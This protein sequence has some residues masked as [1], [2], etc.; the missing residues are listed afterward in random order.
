MIVRCCVNFLGLENRNLFTSERAAVTKS[1]LLDQ[2]I[3]CLTHRIWGEAAYRNM[4]GPK[5]AAPTDNYR[6]I[7]YWEAREISLISQAW[8]PASCFI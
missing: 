2:A 6:G 3:Y 5:T 1:S 7:P 8:G 4:G